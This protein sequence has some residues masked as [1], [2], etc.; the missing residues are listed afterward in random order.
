MRIDAIAIGKNPPNDINVVIEIPIGGEP[1]KY[2]IDKVAGVLVFVGVLTGLFVLGTWLALGFRT[3]VWATGYLFAWPLLL[4]QFSC[5]YSASVVAATTTRNVTAGLFAALACWVICLAVNHSKDTLDIGE[6][7]PVHTQIT[8]A[9]IQGAYWALPK[10]LDFV[11]M[12]DVAVGASEHFAETT[13]TDEAE[14]VLSQSKIFLS[15]GTSAIFALV[16]LGVAARQ[17][18]TMDY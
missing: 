5:I 15:V 11:A 7:A 2:E 16:M 17:L 14:S 4:L 10:P 6:G 12:L 8:R 13:E 9:A 18:S 3:R 1:I